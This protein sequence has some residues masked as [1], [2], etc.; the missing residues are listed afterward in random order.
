MQRLCGWKTLVPAWR[1]WILSN[2]LAKMFTSCGYQFL[3]GKMIISNIMVCLYLLY[4]TYKINKTFKQKGSELFSPHIKNE[5]RTEFTSS[6][7]SSLVYHQR[8]RWVSGQCSW[9]LTHN[10]IR[11]C[12]TKKTQFK[13]QICSTA[14]GQNWPAALL[15][16]FRSFSCCKGSRAEINCLPAGSSNAP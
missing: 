10:L 6:L 14:D 9:E 8:F 12:G 15:M 5:P 3:Q 2:H 7:T 11:L 16:K 1:R 4:S 13:C